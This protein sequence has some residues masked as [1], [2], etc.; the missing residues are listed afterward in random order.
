MHAY[1]TNAKDRETIPLYIA[2]ISV[3][4]ALLLSSVVKNLQWQVPWWLDAPSVM[5]F[6]G[7]FYQAFD[8]FFWQLKLG[9]L[10]CSSIPNLQGTSVG[11]IHSSYNDSDYDG[12]ILYVRQ[13]W[14]AINIQLRATS[15][16]SN[17]T[18]AAVNTL[19]SSEATLK[20]EYV[21]E[22]ST[23]S[24]ST[25]SMHRGSANLR[26]SPDGKFLEGE[27]FNGR[28]RQT[29][30]EMKFTLITRKYINRPLHKITLLFI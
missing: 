19:D 1:A 15:S 22:P 12:I 18:M 10:S 14:S 13:T 24:L 6:Y 27:Y 11:K 28:G 29:F 8:K 21:N 4:A 7:I 9:D 26:L 17:S 16:I 23:R 2:A 25:M 30:G 5:G 3:M 20:H